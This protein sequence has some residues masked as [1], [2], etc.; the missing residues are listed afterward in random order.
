MC[1]IIFV[2]LNRIFF[3]QYHK[4]VAYIIWIKT[5]TLV[6]NSAHKVSNGIYNTREL[7]YKKFCC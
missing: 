7:G 3:V 1:I 5:F 2:I 4:E 6:K